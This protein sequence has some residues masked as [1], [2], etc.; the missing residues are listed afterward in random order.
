[1]NG[2]GADAVRSAR[3]I[4]RRRRRGRGRRPRRLDGWRQREVHGVNGSATRTA[5]ISRRRAGPHRACCSTARAVGT[6]TRREVAR[7]EKRSPESRRRRK[8]DTP[9]SARPPDEA[10]VAAKASEPLRGV[11]RDPRGCWR[12]PGPR[13]R[14]RRDVRS[15][16]IV[17]HRRT[18]RDDAVINTS[19][20]A[21]RKRHRRGLNSLKI[22]KETGHDRV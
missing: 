13:R 11:A 22:E 12:R 17:P 7:A 4:A 10:L 1:M 16:T 19:P 6:R 14:R 21:P 8:V 5:R 18:A 3:T 2:A 20:A 9:R 15:T